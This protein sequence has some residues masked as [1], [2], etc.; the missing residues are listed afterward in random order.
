MSDTMTIVRNLQLTIINEDEKLRKEQYKFI[1]DSQYAQYL[2]LNRCMGYLMSGYYANNM[3][4]SS[5]S[6]KDF[7][8]TIKNSCEC[9][10]GIEFGKGI[11]SKSAITQKVKKDF[12]TALKNGLAKG[13]RNI[14]NYKRNF[15][16][17]TRGRD[18]KFYQES[19]SDDIYIKWVN[20]IIFKVVLCKATNKNYVELQHTLHKVLNGEYKV[21]QSSLEF[22]KHNKL[23]LHLS[24]EI[25]KKKLDNDIIEGRVVGVDVG[26][27]IPAYVQLN[28]VDYIGEGIGCYEDLTKVKKQF[29]VRRRRLQSQLKLCNGGHGRKKKL[30]RLESLQGKEKAYTQT[31]NHNISKRVIEFA[32]KNKAGQINM[33]LLKTED[34]ESMMSTIRYWSYYQLQ[35]MIKY[36]AEKE[37]IIVKTV[38]PYL[39]SQTCSKCGHYE[40]GQRDKQNHFKCKCCGHEEN[41][42]R[43]A[44]RNIAKSTYYITKKEESQYYKNKNNF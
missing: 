24:M 25:P 43:N 35:E 9:F 29:D 19:N 12:S 2:G 14:T 7:Q 40:K 6:F 42:D 41:A 34:D 16:L 23:M 4:I 13:E 27:A 11:D 32:K 33:E 30:R 5:K 21:C 37:G 31:Y 1:R 3:D 10:N 17:M 22:N 38:D 18:L 36:K 8:R 44:S 26:M 15:P 28:D 20:K 39:T